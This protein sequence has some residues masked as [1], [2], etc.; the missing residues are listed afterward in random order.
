MAASWESVAVAPSCGSRWPCGNDMFGVVQLVDQAIN[1]WLHH[2]SYDSSTMTNWNS[3]LTWLMGG[4][5]EHLSWKPSKSPSTIETPV[6]TCPI[7]L[8]DEIL[9]QTVISF[10][11]NHSTGVNNPH[12]EWSA[13]SHVGKQQLNGNW[14]QQV[15]SQQPWVHCRVDQRVMSFDIK[16]RSVPSKAVVL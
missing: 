7:N 11:I 9:K 4:W 1:E 3:S 6:S 15:G 10:L 12:K 5:W 14:A 2:H 13:Y 16:N 8:N